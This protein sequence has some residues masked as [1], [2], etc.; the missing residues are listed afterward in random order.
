MIQ[1]FQSGVCRHLEICWGYVGNGDI[2]W[3]LR[4]HRMDSVQDFLRWGLGFRVSGAVRG[5]L[6]NTCTGNARDVNSHCITSHELQKSY[7]FILPAQATRSIWRPPT[8]PTDQYPKAPGTTPRSFPDNSTKLLRENSKQMCGCSKRER[9]L[10]QP[11]RE[12]GPRGRTVST[13]T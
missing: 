8:H 5:S 9:E 2:Q 3:V 12:V 7:R 4:C 13:Q 6:N 1:G 10:K 11:N